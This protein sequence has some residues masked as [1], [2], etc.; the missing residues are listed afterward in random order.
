MSTL[1]QV[2]VLTLF[3]S[4]TLLVVGFKFYGRTGLFAAFL[5]CALYAYMFFHRGVNTLFLSRLKKEGLTSNPGSDPDGLQVLMNG[6]REL[7]DLS[8]VRLIYSETNMVPL[9]W[10]DFLDQGFVII[11]AEL[12]RRLDAEEK[13]ILAHWLLAHLTIHATLSRRFLA[14]LYLSLKP[15]S[16]LLV[17]VF[18]TLAFC[19]RF[20]DQIY[21]ADLLALKN[22]KVPLVEYSLFLRKLHNFKKHRQKMSRGERFFTPLS[23]G[24]KGLGAPILHLILAPS[25]DQRTRR[26]LGYS[27]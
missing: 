16:R 17:I 23:F 21:Q 2:W 8:S 6:L 18:N 10:R 27:A 3:L 1:T 26:I 15:V 11:N 12:V 24:R 20:N 14:L 5:V 13:R 19:F 7:Y 22:S 4:S 25:F 9:L